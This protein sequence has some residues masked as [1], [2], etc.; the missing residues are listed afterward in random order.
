MGNFTVRLCIQATIYNTTLESARFCNI[1]ARCLPSQEVLYEIR[2]E[3]AIWLELAD[4]PSFLPYFHSKYGKYVITHSFITYC[5]LISEA[6]P[7]RKSIRTE[8]NLFLHIFSLNF[9]FANASVDYFLNRLL[10]D[11][12]L[13]TNSNFDI[14]QWL[15]CNISLVACNDAY[16]YA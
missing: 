7:I 15:F 3:L 12:Q 8:T 5:T 4:A 2:F 10:P 14:L 6:K 9:F 13:G 11:V 1:Q 16:I